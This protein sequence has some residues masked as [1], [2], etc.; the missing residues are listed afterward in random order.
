LKSDLVLCKCDIEA[1]YGLVS[2]K[3]GVSY[4]C[5]HMVD[6]DDVDISFLLHEL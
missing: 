5:G 4:F 2:S 6:Y 1:K 3:L